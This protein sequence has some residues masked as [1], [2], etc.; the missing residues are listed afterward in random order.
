MLKQ[1][2]SIRVIDAIAGRISNTSQL[3]G[4]VA[5]VTNDVRDGEWHHIVFIANTQ[6]HDPTI[7]NDYVANL[8]LDGY[9]AAQVGFS[10]PTTLAGVMASTLRLNHSFTGQIS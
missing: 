4:N 5:E 9:R 10:S 1:I 2:A 7:Y 6:A 8:Y 3:Q